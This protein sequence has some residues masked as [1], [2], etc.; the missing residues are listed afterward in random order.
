ML[1]TFPYCHPRLS[2]HLWVLVATAILLTSHPQ[3]LGD[4]APHPSAAARAAATYA[5]QRSTWVQAPSNSVEA[6]KFARAAFDWSG[7]ATNRSSRAAI[8]ELGITACRQALSTATSAPIHYYLALNLGRIAETRGL[9]ALDLIHQMEQEL[10]SARALDETFDHAGADRTLGLLYRD[11]PG[12]PVSLGNWDKARSHLE[13]AVRI[14]GE[15]P[16]NRLALAELFSRTHQKSL[17]TNELRALDSLWE[18]A[19]GRLNG[20]DWCEAWRDWGERRR[21]LGPVSQSGPHP[22]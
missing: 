4:G 16:E 7:F 2:W 10:L 1:R 6:W 11:A 5:A 22:P 20:I 8:A 19:R 14:D 9:S 21:K 3:L 15:F 17:L 12:W 13:A 18:P